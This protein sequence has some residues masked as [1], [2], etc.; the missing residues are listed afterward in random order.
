MYLIKIN[1]ENKI[2]VVLFN[3]NIKIIKIILSIFVCMLYIYR[4]FDN[5]ILS[6]SLIYIFF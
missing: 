2:V 5:Y 6:G 1:L 4:S 3:K